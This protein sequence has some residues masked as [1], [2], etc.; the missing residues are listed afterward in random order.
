MAYFNRSVHMERLRKTETS[1][2]PI[3][4]HYCYTNLFNGKSLLS[5]GNYMYQLLKY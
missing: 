1:P 2:S 3:Q 4:N 5:S